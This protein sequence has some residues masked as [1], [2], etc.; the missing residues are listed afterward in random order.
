MEKHRIRWT[1]VAISGHHHPGRIRPSKPLCSLGGRSGRDPR[2][3][4]SLTSP[5]VFD[6]KLVHEFG[7]AC[8]AHPRP[9]EYDRG[10]RIRQGLEDRLSPFRRRWLVAC[11]EDVLAG[12]VRWRGI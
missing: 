9:L 12:V 1:F 2:A 8:G 11:I 5:I 4:S 7:K 10:N 3:R 6:A